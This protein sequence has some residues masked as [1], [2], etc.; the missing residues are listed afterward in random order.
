MNPCC[1]LFLSHHHHPVGIVLPCVKTVQQILPGYVFFTVKIQ[2]IVAEDL[3]CVDNTVSAVGQTIDKPVIFVSVYG[4]K[5]VCLLF[6]DTVN[7]RIR[8]G[9]YFR[10]LFTSAS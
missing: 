1:Y 7:A 4:Q 6:P 10:S 9:G 2:I 8:G 5:F 3:L